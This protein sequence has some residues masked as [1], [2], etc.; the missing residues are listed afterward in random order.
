MKFRLRLE[1]KDDLE[2][3]RI[4][5]EIRTLEGDNVGM[6]E[7]LPLISIKNGEMMDASFQYDISNLAEGSY[8]LRLTLF[9]LND[10]GV[11]KG[12]DETTELIYFD[13]VEDEENRTNW[14]PQYW[15]RIKLPPV[16]LIN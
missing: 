13:I 6:S 16:E 8:T 10:M 11:H 3:V 2:G 9:E 12:F 1:G 4:R 5:L 15:G 14:L 7:S